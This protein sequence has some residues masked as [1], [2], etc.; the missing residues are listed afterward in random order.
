[1][2][3][4]ITLKNN[5]LPKVCVCNDCIMYLDANGK[6]HIYAEK[7]AK[8]YV[9]AECEAYKKYDFALDG[10]NNYNYAAL[11]DSIYRNIID[12]HTVTNEEGFRRCGFMH[13]KSK[14]AY[15]GDEL[16][17]KT[18][19]ADFNYVKIPE[20]CVDMYYDQFKNGTRD[21]NENESSTSGKCCFIGESG[22]HYSYY[23]IEQTL[24]Y[25][26]QAKLDLSDREGIKDYAFIELKDNPVYFVLFENGTLHSWNMKYNDPDATLIE[27]IDFTDEIIYDDTDI[28][29][30][31]LMSE[32]KCISK[33]NRWYL[34]VI[35]KDN[36]IHEI[37]D[38]GS[39]DSMLTGKEFDENSCLKIINLD[40]AVFFLDSNGHI[41]ARKKY[42][43]PDV[44]CFEITVAVQY[45]NNIVDFDISFNESI[46]VAVNRDGKLILMGKQEECEKYKKL[47]TSD[48]LI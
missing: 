25:D 38:Y 24:D 47:L 14:A 41:K 5:G 3:E 42:A 35:D 46:G 10:N 17:Y 6:P 34:H 43:D 19:E 37:G 22:K 21:W 15:N 18:K 7:D 23:L 4:T 45:I 26:F 27:T 8:R 9:I 12:I 1:M 28:P 48:I 32:I 33:I 2:K 29:D 31:L 30:D 39:G 44:G 20:K 16:H 36:R 11:G 13:Y 40:S